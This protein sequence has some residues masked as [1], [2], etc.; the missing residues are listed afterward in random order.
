MRTRVHE[1]SSFCILSQLNPLSTFP[2]VALHTHFTIQNSVGAAIYGYFPW[3]PKNL[4]MPLIQTITICET[5][6]FDVYVDQELR[7]L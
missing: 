6:D 7:I 1:S 3:A 5:Y 2:N 4:D